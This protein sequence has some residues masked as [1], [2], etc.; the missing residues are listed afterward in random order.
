MPTTPSETTE[1]PL[2]TIHVEKQPPEGILN[3]TVAE[4]KF[5][6][7]R[8]VPP[9]DMRPFVETFWTV[10]WDLRGQDPFTSENLPH[11]SVNISFEPDIVRFVGVTTGKFLY[12]LEGHGKVLG[13]KFRPGGFYPFIERP[14]SDFTDQSIPVSE[15]LDVD[16]L[17][18]R[19]AM[20]ALDTDV[21]M[22]NYAVNFLRGYVPQPDPMVDTVNTIVKNIIHDRNLRKV[23]DVA[24]HAHLSKRS[25][26]RLFHQYVGV[27]P[28]WVIQRY[29]LHG[30][31]EQ[32]SDPT[33]GDCLQL[34]LE[35]GY[36]DQAH[37]TRDFKAIVGTSPMEYA[38]KLDLI[39]E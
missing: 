29:R 10:R 5:K 33:I 8:Y 23:D 6:L 18:L 34:A 38:K 7:T 2:E 26:Q 3:Q 20:Q 32:L 25:L 36:F 14:M 9:D 37:F 19:E 31:L 17:A 12:H 22:V 15:V 39:H 24:E 21:E 4:T 1:R 35:L 13:I 30:A 16:E 11:P 28:K 27:G